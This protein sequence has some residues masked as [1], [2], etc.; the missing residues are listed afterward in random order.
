MTEAEGS[1]RERRSAHAS[2]EEDA[3]ARSAPPEPAPGPEAPPARPAEDRDTRIAIPGGETRPEPGEAGAAPF[4]EGPF[5]DVVQYVVL[6]ASQ[7]L[8]EIPFDETGEKRVLPREAKG[9]IDLLSALRERTKDDLSKEAASALDNVLSD[10]RMRY[11][12]LG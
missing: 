7:C 6:R 9:Y 10:L 12:E 8:G 4:P 11:L 3:E 2:E 5:F 1:Y